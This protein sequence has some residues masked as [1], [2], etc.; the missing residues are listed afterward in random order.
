[1]SK[2]DKIIQIVS[3]DDGMI[4]GLSETGEVYRLRRSVEEN[5]RTWEEIS[6]S[7]VVD[8]SACGAVERKR[9]RYHESVLD[10]LGKGTTND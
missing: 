2:I 3:G 6:K 9:V 5:P 7:P 10:N 4:F 1:M 8:N